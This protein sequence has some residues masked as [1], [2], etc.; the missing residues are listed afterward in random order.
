MGHLT[1]FKG[2]RFYHRP[3]AEHNCVS[4]AVKCQ[5]TQEKDLGVSVADIS[6]IQPL[7]SEIRKSR[8]SPEEDEKLRKGFELYG[9]AHKSDFKGSIWKRICIEFFPNRT[10]SQL[11]RRWAALQP[12]LKKGR[13]HPSEDLALL[14]VIATQ[15]L[16]TPGGMPL[17]TTDSMKFFRKAAEA[18]G[19]RNSEA[20]YN[21]F[22]RHWKPKLHSM[23]PPEWIKY[24]T[25]GRDLNSSQREAVAKALRSL[26]S[27]VAVDIEA[28]IRQAKAESVAVPSILSD[29]PPLSDDE[30]ELLQR[31]FDVYGGRWALIQREFP[32]RSC[33]YLRTQYLKLIGNDQPWQ[34]DEDRLLIKG[35]EEFEET[36]YHWVK[37]RDNY[38]PHRTTEQLSHRYR[39]I[40]NPDLH[41]TFSKED[42]QKLIDGIRKYGA[43]F[44]TIRRE[45][46]P[47][48]SPFALEQCYIYGGVW[49]VFSDEFTEKDRRTLEMALEKIGPKW[50]DICKEH[51]PQFSANGLRR[52]WESTLPRKKGF[53]PQEWDLLVRLSNELA[54]GK[55]TR[56][57]VAYQM[58]RR[59]T[60]LYPYIRSMGATKLTN[61]THR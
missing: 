57:D 9:T 42:K 52:Q 13:W 25:Q 23:L 10:P 37:T 48:R 45:L 41:L 26:A 54:E 22:V 21:R 36:G 16:H 55:I 33:Q 4:E 2:L 44:K 47:H 46:L 29:F 61:G 51:F 18:V 58:K 31:L 20:C 7:V 12:G 28:R 53:T 50:P 39:Y 11:R 1:A 8:W 38:L 17:K 3:Q 59:W 43:D 6:S 30:K 60:S 40:A 19:S 14:K 5:L 56:S 27:N 49:K 15:P 34:V 24:L 32:T 35:K